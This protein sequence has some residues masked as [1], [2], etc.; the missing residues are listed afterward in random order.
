MATSAGTFS[1]MSVTADY[2][3]GI[4][5]TYTYSQEMDAAATA[6]NL[7][8]IADGQLLPALEQEVFPMMTQMGVLPPLSATFTYLNSDGSEIW[9]R[10]FTAE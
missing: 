7:D 8:E 6:R 9:S 3:S 1:D 4:V 5:Y 10:T 2:P